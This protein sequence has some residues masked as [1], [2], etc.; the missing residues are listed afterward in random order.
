MNSAPSPYLAFI[1]L[2]RIDTQ[3]YEKAVLSGRLMREID[4]NMQEIEQA[5][6]RVR[7]VQNIMHG[8]RKSIDE[9]ELELRI[10]KE[11]ERDIKRKL[12]VVNSVKEYTSLQHEL[13]EV[14]NSQDSLENIVLPLLQEYDESHIAVQ[15]AQDSAEALQQKNILIIK[16]KRQQIASLTKEMQDMQGERER[17]VLLVQPEVL[18]Q[19][20][21]MKEKVPNPAVPVKD[22]TCTACFYSVNAPDMAA[23]RRHKMV[24]C[25]D[26]YRF[27]Y[28]NI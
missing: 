21:A 22:N 19:Y 15:Q 24:T 23:M 8:I 2:A 11:R 4:A 17:I 3:V 5:Q 7:D 28:E 13:E 6:V 26:C 25:K 27:L 14:V 9:K 1:S 16:N 10:L 12:D 20:E 18:H